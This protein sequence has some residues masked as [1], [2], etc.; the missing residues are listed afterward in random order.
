MSQSILVPG[1]NCWAVHN[2]DRASLL[3]DGEAYYA[4][5]EKALRSATR[6]IVIIG[7][8]FD[9]RVRLRPQ[10][11]ENAPT[12]GALLRRL[13]EERPQL[14]VRILVW[15]LAL[16]HTPSASMSLLLG[17]EWDDHPRI[18]LRLDTNH[19][20]HAAH[21]QKIVVIDDSLAFVG[22]MDVTVDRWDTPRHAIDEPL[23]VTPD[24]EAFR[25]V[26]DVQMAVDGPVARAIAD[27]ARSRW[28]DATGEDVALTQTIDRWPDD[29]IPHFR[30]VPVAIARTAPRL[31]GT[32][33]VEE[34]WALTTD[35]LRS[36]KRFVYIE[37]QYFT[38]KLL[39]PLLREILSREDPPEIVVIC[40]LNANGLIERFIMGANR[41]R[42]LRSLK[43]ADHA[44]R[45]RLYHSV[46][47]DST[48]DKTEV[49]IHSKIMI[50]DDRLLRVGSAN[51]NNR[52]I[53]LDTEC[54]LAIE[55]D[56]K[57]VRKTIEDFRHQLLAEHLGCDTAEV[58]SAI[59]SSGSQIAAIERLSRTGRRHLQPLAMGRGPKHSFPGTRLLDP[60]RPFGPV[61]ALH[62]L[63]HR[64]A[65]HRP[66][67]AGSRKSRGASSSLATNSIPPSTKGSR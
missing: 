41:E 43:R 30:D 22:G 18:D 47:P 9:G 7:W 4:S 56:E 48:G 2:A 19:P 16:L 14:Q 50:A 26:H 32:E 28:R 53:G 24:G 37:A 21:H 34:A 25:P 52:S 12:V 45:L 13:V 1:R 23:R 66:S 27:L 8:D 38:A 60:V 29:L 11:G 5:L 55:S 61:E 6:S 54:D 51:L 57:G 44:G 62:R 31:H 35:V 64:L 39:R 17:D 15:S 40:P 10:D 42:L 46:V 20:I 59:D 33:A 65:G 36:A 49:L 58:A 3:V 67:G 63:W